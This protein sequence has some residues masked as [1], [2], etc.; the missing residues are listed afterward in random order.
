MQLKAIDLFAG[1]GGFTLAAH[2][3]GVDV[4]AAIEW[5]KAAA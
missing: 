4:V 5:D 3:A 1:A 2:Q